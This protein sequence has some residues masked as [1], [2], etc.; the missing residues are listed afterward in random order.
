MSVEDAAMAV[1]RAE[2]WGERVSLIRRIPER[3]GTGQQKD[4]YSAIAAEVYVPSLAPD[5][6]YVH[7]HERYELEPVKAAYRAARELTEGFTKVSAADLARAIEGAPR[8]LLG[9]RLLI[10]FTA[11]EFAASTEIVAK[12][13]GGRP[14]KLGRI[15]SMEAGRPASAAVAGV[16]AAVVDLAMRG[17]LFPAP[18]TSDLMSKIQKPDTVRGWDSVREYDRGGVPLPMFLH[19]RHYGGAFRQLLD[20]TSTKRGDLLEDA[21]ASLFDAKEIPYT[22]TGAWKQGEIEDR[23]G[24]TVQPA[25][26]FIVYSRSGG[27]VGNL[28]AML[29]CKLANDGGTARDKAARFRSLRA[30]AARLGGIPVFAVLGGLG[31]TRTADALGPVVR[32]TDG[33]TFTLP[34][35]EEML[36]VEPFPGLI[37]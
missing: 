3:F 26:D 36:T 31:W 15:K 25:P 9:F 30:E 35:L 1:A 27:R 21:V 13:A 12:R 10:G 23:F 16:C 24:L 18:S 19:Q 37:R 5:F 20:A 28:L 29:E 22:R 33:R 14:I 6:A 11:P 7:R 32:D 2:S 8:S 4:V 34:T 17:E